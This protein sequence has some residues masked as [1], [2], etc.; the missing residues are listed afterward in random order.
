MKI[1]KGIFYGLAAFIVI[2][3]AGIL[4]IAS[5]PDVTESI[6]DFT[7]SSGLNSFV[8]KH[9]EQYADKP[10]NTPPAAPGADEP[11][12]GP[13]EGTIAVNSDEPIP[14]TVDLPTAPME[15]NGT[16]TGNT[17]TSTEKITPSEKT[18]KTPDNV[19]NL[20]GYDGVR[21][22]DRQISDKD[23]ENLKKSLNTGE[24]G[25]NETFDTEIY[26]YYGMLDADEQKVYKQIYANAKKVT[27]TFAPVVTIKADSLKRVFEAVF[28]DHPELFWVETGYTAKHL[29]DDTVIEITMK[30]YLTDIDA[31]KIK[32]ENA[33]K[34][35]YDSAKNLKTDYEK[36]KAVH[37]YLI[38][39]VSYNA[40]AA[41][42]Q[43]AYSA[44]VNGQSVCAGYARAFQYIMQKLGIPT[45]YCTGYAGED[46]AWN[47]V[48]L[49]DG[50]YNVDVTWDD[51]APSTY[52]YFNRTDKDFVATHIRKNMSVD[53]P[54]CNATEYGGK[55]GQEDITDPENYTTPASADPESARN[56]LNAAGVSEADVLSTL[57]AY[58]ADAKNKLINAGSGDVMFT[59]VV[60]ANL[61]STLEYEYNSGKYQDGYV[62]DALK[63]L[64]MNKFAINLQ[65]QSIGGGYYRLYHNIVTWND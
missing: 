29:A 8:Q 35:I 62:N 20:H 31:A 58:Y 39:H 2:L 43:S 60:D 38:S 14:V 34:V 57:S 50:Y 32:F 6:A 10:E 55:E 47:I 44:L 51:T 40:S 48:K 25:D 18:V 46:H 49:Y 37:D 53:L 56:A 5:N 19:K 24:T 9:T 59:S 7:R 17:S 28:N 27:R 65:A 21:D 12:A 64:G 16:D 42:N 52:N 4:A 3:C 22:D 1:L 30:Y 11:A 15:Y 45:Y 61:W 54:D 41:M 26:P 63:Q 23:A 36:E 33:A 13:I